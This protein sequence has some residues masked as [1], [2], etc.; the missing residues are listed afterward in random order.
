MSWSGMVR[1]TRPAAD[2]RSKTV[3][4]LVLSLLCLSLQLPCEL[5]L[6]DTR[7]D[8]PLVSRLTAFTDRRVS[9]AVSAAVAAAELEHPE[10]GF[11]SSLVGLDAAK[12]ISAV[13][14][15]ACV[16]AGLDSMFAVIG[17][18]WGLIPDEL[19]AEPVCGRRIDEK[20][21]CWY[22]KY[23][24]SRAPEPAD[25]CPLRPAC[26]G[27]LVALLRA[28][29]A[30]GCRYD[31]AVAPGYMQSLGPGSLQSIATI[32]DD[33]LCVAADLWPRSLE[34]IKVS[35]LARTIEREQLYSKAPNAILCGAPGRSQNKNC[36]YKI[37]HICPQL[38][39]CGC[40]CYATYEMPCTPAAACAS[41]QQ[42][43]T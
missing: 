22:E 26:K 17:S 36:N 14:G 13:V 1:R 21:Q 12:K 35:Q 9:R 31:V 42:L 37:R 3:T 28:L 38:I 2:G 43:C 39:Q 15:M 24:K 34:V 10:A 18:V 7:S 41:T 27:L 32:L 23:S 40:E 30:N 19:W 29:A 16:D 5:A 33:I 11:A 6:A 25:A 8:C 4:A 20:V